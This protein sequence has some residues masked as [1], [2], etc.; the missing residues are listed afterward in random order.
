MS[1][2]VICIHPA[3]TLSAILLSGTR[4]GVCG[5]V[6]AGAIYPYSQSY[7]CPEKSMQ[8]SSPLSVRLIID[9]VIRTQRLGL[10]FPTQ[11]AMT[12][13]RHRDM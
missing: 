6:A 13:D 5:D 12:F 8:P 9:W 1:R 2:T 7:L 4:V 11:S 10:I 3:E